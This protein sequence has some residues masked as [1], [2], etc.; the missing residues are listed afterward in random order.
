MKVNDGESHLGLSDAQFNELTSSVDIIIHNAWKV[1]FNYSL[2]SFKPVHIR[3]VCN[4]IDWSSDIIV[5]VVRTLS[6][7]HLFYPL[8]IELKL[9]KTSQLPKIPS[10]TMASQTKCGTRGPSMWQSVS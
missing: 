4:L 5:A 9:I 2:E 6:F 3:G 8:K 7:Y 10:P 1:D